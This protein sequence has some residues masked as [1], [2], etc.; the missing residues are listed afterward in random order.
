MPCP[1][2]FWTKMHHSRT[3]R[4]PCGLIAPAFRT[5]W[6]F[7]LMLNDCHHGGQRPLLP[8]FDPDKAAHALR[9]QYIPLSVS[10]S[11]RPACD[12]LQISV[13]PRNIRSKA[14]SPSLEVFSSSCVSRPKP[15]L[16]LR[17]CV[18]PATPSGLGYLGGLAASFQPS[19]RLSRSSW[20][21]LSLCGNYPSSLS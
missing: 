15:S 13:A 1:L 17:I 6:L 11:Y 10:M 4:A 8:L 5:V 12:L 20:P 16:V 21:P 7:L 3:P 2:L 18:R 19:R 14:R 9:V